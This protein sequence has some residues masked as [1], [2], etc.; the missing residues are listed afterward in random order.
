[1]RTTILTLVAMI[2]FSSANAAK[3]YC[4]SE[5]FS[6]TQ[7]DVN[8]KKKDRD[9]FEPDWIE[10]HVGNYSLNEDQDN[11]AYYF[12]DSNFKVSVHYIKHSKADKKLAEK[13]GDNLPREGFF[14]TFLSKRNGMSQEI[15][16]DEVPG[17]YILKFNLPMPY[18]ITFFEPKD[19]WWKTVEID[20]YKLECDIF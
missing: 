15:K 5:Y 1:M 17:E 3:L 2:T 18:V 12:E 9:F 20:Q 16:L 7:R 10:R 13:N 11:N 14:L 4:D 8:G 19:S 6:K